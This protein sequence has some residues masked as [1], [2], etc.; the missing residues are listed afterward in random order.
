MCK[1]PTPEDALLFYLVGWITE[2]QRAHAGFFAS[3]I[4]T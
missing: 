1:D 2:Y 3:T 4:I